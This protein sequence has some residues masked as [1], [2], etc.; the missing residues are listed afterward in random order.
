MIK[1]ECNKWAASNERFGAMAA[2]SPQKRQFVIE[3]SSPAGSSV[4]AATAPSRH[5]V[6]CKFGGQRTSKMK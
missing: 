4:N 3:S 6:V 5:H 2:A 1:N